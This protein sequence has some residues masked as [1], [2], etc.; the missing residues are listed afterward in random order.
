MQQKCMVQDGMTVANSHALLMVLGGPGA[1]KST[2]L[3]RVGLEAL[4][5]KE[6]QFQHD[7]IPV[8]LELKTIR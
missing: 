5:V 6:S 8:M 3:R 1:G 4:R 2:Y 7:C